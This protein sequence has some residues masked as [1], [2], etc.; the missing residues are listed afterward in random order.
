MIVH[1]KIREAGLHEKEL[2][3]ML[4][5]LG[6]SGGWRIDCGSGAVVWTDEMYRIHGLSPDRFEPS[7]KNFLDLTHPDD[8]PAL[9]AWLDAALQGGEPPALEY[10]IVHPDGEP[11]T[12]AGRV[13]F[14]RAAEGK[15][16]H[17]VGT[18]RD[19]SAGK[20]AESELQR[21]EA[22][23]R[24]II[25]Q[26][27]VPYALY[28][29]QRRIAHLNAAFIAN[30]GYDAQDIPTLDDWLAQVH[31]NS[32]YRLRTAG[33]PPADINGHVRSQGSE[34]TIRCKDGTI[35]TAMT[36]EILL[37]DG[38]GDRLFIFYNIAAHGPD[39]LAL[40]DSRDR[41]VQAA[42]AS[43]IGVWDWDIASGQLLWDDSMF[44]LY[45]I[46]REDFSGAYEA[47]RQCLH[48]DDRARLEAEVRASITEKKPFNTEFRVMRPDGEILHIKSYGE[49]YCDERGEVRRMLGTNWDITE[50]KRGEDALRESHERLQSALEASRTGTWRV[51]LRSGM[52]TRDASLNRM[53]GLPAQPSMQVLDDW[54][55]Y[56][57]PD[58]LPVMRLAWEEALVT[59]L[60]KVEHR[61]I[62]RDGKV[63]WVHDR[64][65]M[66]RDAAG[67]PLYAIGAAMDI[68][69]RM[70]AQENMKL[71]TSI[72]QASSE[73]IMVTDENNL[74][75]DVNPAFTRI[76]GYELAEV[77]GQDPK[78]L[79][80]G[81]HDQKFYREMWQTILSEGRWQGEIWDRRKDGELYAKWANI[82]IIRH[83]D[84]SVYR[85]VAQFADITEKKQKDELIWKQANYDVLTGLPNRRLLQDRLE[86]EI[87]KAHR[88]G[89][90]LALLFIDL[91]HF[92]VINDT[93]GHSA[94]DLM[95]V[96]AARRIGGCVRE[97]DTI[98]RLGG[99]EFTAIL[100][101]LG[102]RMQV[103]RIAH[104]I[105]QELS[106]PFYFENDEVS[107]Y[108][109]ASIGITLYPE[110][111][112]DKEGLL[113][114][115]D[116][117]MY[118]AK[119]EG[120]QRFSYFT[121]S[122]QR[123][124]REKLALIHDLR[125][126][127]ARGEL[128][129]YY[130]PILELATGRIVKA[131]ALLR[132]KHPERGLVRPDL[133]I[134]LAEESGLIYEIGDW[135]FQ[136]AIAGVERWRK[137]FGRIVSVCV[138]KSPVQFEYPSQKLTWPI[139]LTSLGLPGNSIT[140]EITEGSLLKA[141]AKTA[142]RLLEFRNQGI[143]VSIDDFGT[144]F[145]SL[146]YLKQFDIDYLKI[147]RSF[148]SNI[149]DDESDKVLTEAIIV[150]AHKLGI[151]TIAEGVEQELQRDMLIAFGCDYAQGFLYS[152]AVPAEEF[153][154]MLEKG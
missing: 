26:S 6:D 118:K 41:L 59:G 8:R 73:A 78:L 91:D 147:D 64:G 137:Q 144:G 70:L 1:T 132:W 138:N 110:D 56:I 24:A 69:E 95:L 114:R 115:A 16:G 57:H 20:R 153:E 99:D 37:G 10:R 85:Y 46:R 50:R 51:D 122:M 5:Q 123:E 23:L 86:Q 58:D 80:S 4:R 133:F 2:L 106:R 17:V 49:V 66:V 39:E 7:V 146:S 148:I 81:R 61:L 68:T 75:V 150:M 129:V 134:P 19:I 25:D 79:Q 45:G 35:R 126:A 139:M 109:S 83:P 136:Q 52:D 108:I 96:E 119:A 128:H 88:N 48:K 71:A 89:S 53:L 65:I 98:S 76:T 151:K 47:W 97:A 31:P 130:Q 28:D 12:I 9:E 36:S 44:L 42:R 18:A 116:Q 101:E 127:L 74:I 92:K 40:R 13:S 120:R 125:R 38:A 72:Y 29:A 117:A 67:Q 63:L 62:R 100:P 87:K 131:E 77:M 103:E 135:V 113:K 152:P 21:S 43:G 33:A 54:F 84:G 105:I 15:P 154:R 3:L 60:Y 82:S 30:F 112:Q 90:S 142:Q 145:S 32:K 93:L 27:P 149:T 107:Y 143:E 34:I 141:S 104:H 14:Q 102:D 55:Q 111:A 94:G 140:V 124:A 121:E 11:R 22:D